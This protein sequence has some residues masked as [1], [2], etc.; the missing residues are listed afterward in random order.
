[1]RKSLQLFIAIYILVVFSSC[2]TNNASNAQVSIDSF[3]SVEYVDSVEAEIYYPS[4]EKLNFISFWKKF[5]E[6]ARKHDLKFFKSIANDTL[7]VCESSMIVKDFVETCYEATFDKIF[8]S[9]LGDSSNVKFAYSDDKTGGLQY[10]EPYGSQHVEVGKTENDST[11]Y[12]ALFYFI[13][14][15]S[16]YTF[17]KIENNKNRKC[18]R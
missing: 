13:E 4:K 7:N 1:M 8:F 18:C 3:N 6:S 14:T 2:Q 11:R 9:S 12:I 15:K 17:Y 10:G 16:G 5:A